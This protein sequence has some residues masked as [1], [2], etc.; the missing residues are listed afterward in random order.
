MLGLELTS[1]WDVGQSRQ[2]LYSLHHNTSS[3]QA[4]LLCETSSL[5]CSAVFGNPFPLE[6]FQVSIC[7]QRQGEAGQALRCVVLYWVD[8][9]D[10]VVVGGGGFFFFFFQH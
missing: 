10:F 8:F 9:P 3:G 1:I 7:M 6:P 5:A 4:S 2:E